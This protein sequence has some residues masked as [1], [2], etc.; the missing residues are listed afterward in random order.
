MAMSGVP[1]YG[2]EGLVLREVSLS[3]A[4]HTHG[5]QVY[6]PVIGRLVVPSRYGQR[7]A[8]GHIVEEG[9]HLFVNTG[10][11]TSIIPVRFLVPPEISILELSSQDTTPSR[12]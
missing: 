5:G 8:S 9:R 4:A 10:L 2:C 3:I 7:F 11:G 6:I 1:S 12:Q